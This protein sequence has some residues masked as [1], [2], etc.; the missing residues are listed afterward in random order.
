MSNTDESPPEA[1]ENKATGLIQNRRDGIIAA[2]LTL[3]VLSST[4]RSIV[5]GHPHNAWLFEPPKS[6]P[7]VPLLVGLS[8]F[9][10]AFVS[11]IL[12]WFYRGAQNKYERLLVASFAIG[13]V[14]S[15][16]EGFVPQALGI[17]L[18]LPSAAAFF[19]S[20]L[21]ALTLVGKFSSKRLP[22]PM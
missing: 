2:V 1:D 9:Y 12:F 16:V 11:W 20:C 5:T 13:F 18:E 22:Q 10:W 7:L 8:L 3:A 4:L 17:N 21:A 6:G 15:I 19:I 14:L